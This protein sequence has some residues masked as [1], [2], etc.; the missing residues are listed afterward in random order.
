[1]L[2]AGGDLS[3]RLINHPDDSTVFE[4]NFKRP[5]PQG[6]PTRGGIFH[7]ETLR[8]RRRQGSNYPDL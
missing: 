5:V 2:L 7:A 4:T 8:D 1:M 3:S 6:R